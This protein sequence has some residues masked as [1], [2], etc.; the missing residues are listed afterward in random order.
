MCVLCDILCSSSDCVCL[1]C[2]G[3]MAWW[4][5]QCMYIRIF[6]VRILSVNIKALV[7]LNE[8]YYRQYE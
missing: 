5:M 7:E 1:D 6:V 4:A 8:L 2:A 3:D